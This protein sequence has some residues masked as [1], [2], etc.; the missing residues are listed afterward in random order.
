M[1]ASET[2]TGLALGV[3]AYGAWGIIPVY[4]KSL[5]AV[6]PYEILAHRVA[7]ALVV[8]TVLLVATGRFRSTLDALRATD[9][10]RAMFVSTALIG[11]NWAIFI[12]AV[13]TSR[14][15]QASLG[16]FM[17]PLC[18]ALLGRIVLGERLS[19][20]QV[21]AFGLA[22][23]GVLWL[24]A[25]GGGVPW[26]ALALAGSFSL[27][28]LV[29]KR[30]A[31]GAIEGFTI[32]TALAAPLALA[33][34]A[35]RTPRFGAIVT[36]GPTTRALLLGAGAVTAGPLLAFAAAAKRLRYTTLGMVQFLAPSMQLG[37]AVV[38]FGEPFPAR[39]KV[40]FVLI[41]AGAL[42]YAL[43]ALRASLP[44]TGPSGS[45]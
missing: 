20:G 40:A 15:M 17:N 21:A 6:S 1:S 27:Y 24:V 36:A 42:V 29:R 2:K 31:V 4:W 30:A 33:Y 10:R 26:V 3:L 32:E 14:L 9:S 25:S 44:R 39:L 45:S 13:A 18:N 19:R 22:A 5:G 41:G 37:C 28:G 12:W 23:A 16:Y 11:I 43:E 34:L 38:L 8:G 35:T 7:G